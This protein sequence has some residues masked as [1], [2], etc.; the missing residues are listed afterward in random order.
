MHV[1]QC[2]FVLTDI[3]RGYALPVCGAS[4]L[5]TH[6]VRKLLTEADLPSLTRYHTRMCVASRVQYRILLMR[7]VLWHDNLI[8]Y[9][10]PCFT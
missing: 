9:S 3:L 7:R 5:G 8:T 10:G 6:V 4:M 1:A 2:T